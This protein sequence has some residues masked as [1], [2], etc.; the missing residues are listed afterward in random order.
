LEPKG[1][2]MTRKPL[3]IGFAAVLALGASAAQAQNVDKASQTFIKD[4][5]EAN[6]A[7]IDAGKLAQDKSASQDIK[8]FADMMVKDHTDA[9]DKAIAVAKEI[10]VTPP[11][12]SSVM[13]KA[14][15]L[16]LKVLSGNTFDRSFRSSMIKDH[17]AVIKEFQKEALRNDAA[18]QFAKATL[19]TLQKHL[20][21]AQSLGAAGHTMGSGSTNK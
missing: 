17:Q 1:H 13:E 20:E 7:E 15:Y 4:A 19:P 8:S 6:Y 21:M 2:V 14:E 10:G 11:T 9:N 3:L 12:G 16:K 18:G 5:I